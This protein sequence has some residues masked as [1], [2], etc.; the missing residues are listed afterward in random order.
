MNDAPLS[1]SANEDYAPFLTALL[2]GDRSQCRAI[3]E[4]WLAADID[5][6]V[7][8]QERVQP[9]LYKV[10][11]LW[12]QGQV[13]VATEHL[14][15]AITEGLLGLVYPRLFDRPHIGKS[16]VVACTANEY[17][18]IGG[19]MVA[20]LF[21]LHGWRGYSLGANTPEQSLLDLIRDKAP[22]AVVL[23]L[24]VRFNLEP[25]LHAAAA[26]RAAFPEV[27]ILVGGQAFRWG[28]RELV[29][30][31]EG[32][33]YLASLDELEGWIRAQTPNAL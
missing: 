17:H 8:Y 7:L 25:L 14:A 12:E 27:P 9:A 15:S 23:S 11:E 2:A 21:E 6:R 16:V 33:R 18:Q 20:D 19:K 30:Q 26:V 32:V 28:G 10:G 13:S 22:D 24:A 5:L 29:E 1:V 4:S 31:I 3:F